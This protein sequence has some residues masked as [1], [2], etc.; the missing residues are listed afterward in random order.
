LN[1]RCNKYDILNNDNVI[2]DKSDPPSIFNL[3][4]T[5]YITILAFLTMTCTEFGIIVTRF[6]KI[7]ENVDL[8]RASYRRVTLF[9]T[10]G[11]Y[12]NMIV[13]ANE[14]TIDRKYFPDDFDAF[15]NERKEKMAEALAQLYGEQNKLT[16]TKIGMSDKQSNLLSDKSVVLEFITSEGSWRPVY[17]TLTEAVL[18][19]T[20][21]IFTITNLDNK[22]FTLNNDDIN[23]VLYNLF[24]DV[25][26][27]LLDSSSYYL[28]DANDHIK[29]RKTIILVMFIVSLIVIVLSIG[30]LFPKVTNV[31]NIRTQ[32][33][34]L[35]LDIPLSDVQGLKKSCAKYLE[36]E[37][38]EEAGVSENSF[39]QEQNSLLD[40]EEE[41]ETPQESLRIRRNS[42]KRRFTNNKSL[43]TNFFVKYTFAI[44]VLSSLYITIYVL[45]VQYLNKLLDCLPEL[46]NTV[47]VPPLDAGVLSM[48][49]QLLTSGNILSLSGTETFD[50]LANVKLDQM[51]NDHRDI[52]HLHLLNKQKYPQLYR[53]VFESIFLNSICDLGI[54]FS[55]DCETYI[56]GITVKG[57]STVLV[58]YIKAIRE[59]ID[60]YNTIKSNQ[61]LSEEEKQAEYGI[62]VNGSSELNR[63]GEAETT[64]H[65][66]MELTFKELLDS[67]IQAYKK[68][69]DSQLLLRII[70]FV[71]ISTLMLSMF[72][73]VWVP[74]INN[75]STEIWR[76]KC[77]LTIIPKEVIAQMKSIQKFLNNP[78]IFSAK[79][80][81]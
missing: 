3:K 36:K 45:S 16:I 35:F 30:F 66:I 14:A 9:M 6:K 17:Y 78:D 71:V 24:K 41:T 29:Y 4:I 20:S 33:L 43:D 72:F 27:K 2:K 8:I 28:D 23:F 13:Y 73:F 26:Y 77:M 53:D 65:E 40:I 44:F 68:M 64:V 38:G 48:T 39:S 50:L 18:Q 47:E 61:A 34:S 69:Y 79:N 63:I 51:Q 31:R 52:Q 55:F 75:L 70:F 21:S 74:F 60:N 19:M 80:E 7:N 25:Y 15:A 67:L 59:L 81:V 46:L 22:Q 10:I 54:D 76:T 32:V 56:S 62:L 11:Y 12:L 49:Q 1:N 57:M 37:K 42:R 5:G 58:Q